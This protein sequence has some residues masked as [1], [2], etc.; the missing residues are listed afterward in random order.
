MSAVMSR[1]SPAS[2]TGIFGRMKNL[3]LK[4]SGLN[5]RLPSA[6]TPPGAACS[7]DGLVLQLRSRGHP[8]H[9]GFS[10]SFV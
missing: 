5:N 2:S 3:K 8:Q 6:L 4:N 9:A 7:L 10:L 1:S